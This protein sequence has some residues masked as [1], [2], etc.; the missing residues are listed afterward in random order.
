MQVN[1]FARK[2][3]YAYFDMKLSDQGKAWTPHNL[4]KTELK[5]F[6][7]GQKERKECTLEFQ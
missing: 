3:D 1:D 2:P 7:S 4:C 6:V 5:L